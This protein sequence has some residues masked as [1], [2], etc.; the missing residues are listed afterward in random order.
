M[1]TAIFPKILPNTKKSIISEKLVLT[2][3]SYCCNSPNFRYQEEDMVSVAA[4]GGDALS[5]TD[6]EDGEKKGL[7]AGFCR[8]I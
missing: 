4:T 7:K 6:E 8:E 5:G 2:N 3:S 1:H